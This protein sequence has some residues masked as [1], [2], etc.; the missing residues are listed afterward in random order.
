[1]FTFGPAFQ[2]YS[3]DSADNPGRD[4][5]TNPDL[6]RPRFL[7]NNLIWVAVILSS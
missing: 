2:Y 7:Q 5:L 6:D 1:M 4:I 3:L